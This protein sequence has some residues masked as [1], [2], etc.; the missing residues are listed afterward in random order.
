M[1]R[2]LCRRGQLG[3]GSPADTSRACNPHMR[4]LS[5]TCLKLQKAMDVFQS[6]KGCPRAWEIV[7]GRTIE[8]STVYFDTR[9][10]VLLVIPEACTSSIYHPLELV[11]S[12]QRCSCLFIIGCDEFA[13][14]SLSW[15]NMS[16]ERQM[17]TS[18]LWFLETLSAFTRVVMITSS[19]RA[20]SYRKTS[21]QVVQ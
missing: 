17:E 13:V 3:A 6:R 8:L 16:D 14:I 5:V 21:H 2:I 18:V 12:L 11:A 1:S 20:P 19:V 7:Q 9:L 10:D 4:D 15:P